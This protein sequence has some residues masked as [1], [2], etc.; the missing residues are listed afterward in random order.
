MYDD[1]QLSNHRIFWNI[2]QGEKNLSSDSTTQKTITEMIFVADDIT[3]GNYLCNL[4]VP[5]IDTDAVPSRPTFYELT[6][7]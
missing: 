3:D 6:L 5:E 7:E 4:Q 2:I 1:G